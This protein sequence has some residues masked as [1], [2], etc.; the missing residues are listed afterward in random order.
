MVNN[1]V[2]HAKAV[3]LA[4]GLME[5]EFRT[6]SAAPHD[7]PEY[8]SASDVALAF[9]KPSFSKRSSSPTKYAEC[10]AMGLPL[11]VSRD[12]GDSDAIA[13]RE[14]G[15]A[16]RRLDDASLRAALVEL[17]R[18]LTM[19]REHFRRVASDL[20]DIERVAL[21]AY[22]RIYEQLVH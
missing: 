16:L 6:L 22:Q 21:P 1:D 8:L 15:L 17:P 10:L 19:G 11:V 20:F 18:L 14:G 7:V 5:R 12:V 4:E 9:I 2:A 13:L 3:S